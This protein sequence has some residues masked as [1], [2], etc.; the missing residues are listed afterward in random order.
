L[1]RF[2]GDKDPGD[3]N[4]TAEAGGEWEVVPAEQVDR[5]G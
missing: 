4:G 3:T 5:S 1:Y 2:T